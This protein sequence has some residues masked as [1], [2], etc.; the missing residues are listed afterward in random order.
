MSPHF[1]PNVEVKQLALLVRVWEIVGSNLGPELGYSGSGIPGFL[2]QPR[3]G[4]YWDCT[5]NKAS[6]TTS[7][8][9][10]PNSSF[11]NHSMIRRDIFWAT[12]DIVKQTIHKAAYTAARSSRIS[13]TAARSRRLA[14]KAARSSR[15]SYTA[16]RSRRLAYTAARSR[17]LAC[18]AGR[19][20]VL[21][22]AADRPSRPVYT[23]GESSRLG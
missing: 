17:R 2:S 5:L 18:K 11:T 16:A 9:I 3:T 1:L 20:R 21:A 23:D 14:F 12:T 10:T 7:F 4:T 15:I 13:Y 22:Y 8:N 6:T 19:Q